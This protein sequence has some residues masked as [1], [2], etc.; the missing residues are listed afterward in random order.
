MLFEISHWEENF[1]QLQSTIFFASDIYSLKGFGGN[2]HEVIFCQI[3][4]LICSHSWFIHAMLDNFDC[5]A[6]YFFFANLECFYTQK[7]AD[8]IYVDVMGFFSG[9]LYVIFANEFPMSC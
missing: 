6:N 7:A 5:E 9:L 4:Q 8:M 2:L 3:Q 1:A